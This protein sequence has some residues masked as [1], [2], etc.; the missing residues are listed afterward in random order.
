MIIL[1]WK[2]LIKYKNHFLNLIT[3]RIL[4]PG[5]T[6]NKAKTI[7]NTQIIPEPGKGINNGTSAAI[8][9]IPHKI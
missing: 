9:I 3:W 4:F 6:V 1:L 7:I 5:T 2:F 8:A